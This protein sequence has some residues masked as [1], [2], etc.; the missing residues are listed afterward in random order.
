MPSFDPPSPPPAAI[1]GTWDS[2]FEPVRDAFEKNFSRR[3]EVGAAVAVMVEGE[4]VV[5]LW[6]GW[7]D[8]DHIRPWQADTLVSAQSTTKGLV[9][10]LFHWLAE[11]GALD[12]DRPVSDYWPEFAGA[13]KDRIT[14]RALISHQAG[15]C[16]IDMPLPPGATLDWSQMIG[17]LE[18]Q[19]PV[20]PP[21]TRFGYHAITWSLL[22]GELAWR[23]TGE[24][25]PR[26]FDRVFA[27]PW[28]LD[29]YLGLPA[30][31]FERTA[32][33]LT[34]PPGSTNV[35]TGIPT[36]FRKRAFRLCPS[37]PGISA[38]SPQA[39][40]AP[41]NG[42]GNARGIAR[43][44]GG[45][46]NGG[47]LNGQRL[48]SEQVTRS[49]GKTEVEGIDAVLGIRR[50][51]GLGFWLHYPTRNAVRGEH[52]FGHPG[53]GGSFGFADPARRLGLSYTMNLPGAFFAPPTSN[54]RCIAV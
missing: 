32:E 16:V 8:A 10:V 35:P 20:W 28:D 13:G 26:L 18:A 12:W 54:S 40:A 24:H 5:D 47:V 51:F 11:Q 53:L 34:V 29:F 25:L 15:L 39:R 4:L 46:G 48:L 38:N 6:G 52:A 43:L 23:I 42:F 36:P 19:T 45:L 7:A 33:F 17:A 49:L 22:M 41:G 14:T 1:S 27:K 44:F 30:A 2:K 3:G 21:G 50:R 9:A 37:L 31:E